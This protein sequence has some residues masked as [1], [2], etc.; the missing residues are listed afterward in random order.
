MKQNLFLILPITIFFILIIVAGFTQSY[1]YISNIIFCIASASLGI[2]VTFC[3]IDKYYDIKNKE[4]YKPLCTNLK[5]QYAFLI[6]AFYSLI[7]ECID[8]QNYKYNFE[9]QLF[10][11]VM[12]EEIK[13]LKS[14]G[15]VLNLIKTTDVDKLLNNFKTNL[16]LMT[17]LISTMPVNFDVYINC[18]PKIHKAVQVFKFLELGINKPKEGIVN[19]QVLFVNVFFEFCLC[20]IEEIQ[21]IDPSLINNRNSDDC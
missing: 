8:V 6:Q 4:T 11:D 5:M 14:Y 21:K 3:V 19:P 2:F 12:I 1:E 9:C 16:Q 20:F 15:Q 18:Y 10:D 13:T 7:A 17:T